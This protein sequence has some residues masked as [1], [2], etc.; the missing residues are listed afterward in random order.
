LTLNPWC[1]P[2]S[3]TRT[4]RYSQLARQTSAVDL[5]RDLALSAQLLTTG[6]MA[7]LYLAFSIAVLP[8]LARGSDRTFVEA[9]RSINAAIL[10][11]W[12]FVVFLGPLFL[13]VV[14]TATRLPDH[15]GLGWTAL[16]LGLYAATLV[17]TGVVNVP[18]NNRL[19]D[20][21]PDEAAR[22]SFER[23]WVRWNV[24]RTVL[25]IASFVALAPAL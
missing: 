20:T 4:P 11:G 14:A 15:A 24:V 17:I 6:L 13:G 16:A 22:S 23:G 12:F 10:N 9:M 8:G 3:A 5:A 7:G 21:E 2:H 18:L 25:S 1:T 19:D